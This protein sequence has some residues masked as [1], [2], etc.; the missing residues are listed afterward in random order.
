M[1]LQKITH[2]L[3]TQQSKNYY[4]SNSGLYTLA[5]VLHLAF[6]VDYYDD[7]VAILQ[8]IHR[9]LSSTCCCN[10]VQCYAKLD[11]TLSFWN[12]AEQ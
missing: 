7:D 4:Y 10:A 6:H 11:K 1:H 9:S 5:C 2:A 3:Q 8:S 12:K